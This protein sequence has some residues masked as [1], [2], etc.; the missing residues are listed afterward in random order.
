MPAEDKQN[1]WESDG[2]LLIS[3]VVSTDAENYDGAEIIGEVQELIVG[4]TDEFIL[5]LKNS[6]GDEELRAFSFSAFQY[7]QSA[8]IGKEIGLLTSL[9]SVSYTHL[10]LPTTR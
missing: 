9:A 4:W 3:L 7:E 2:P 10:T 1:P 5:D 6:T 8:N